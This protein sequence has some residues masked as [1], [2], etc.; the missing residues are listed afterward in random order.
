MAADLWSAAQDASTW[1]KE[2]SRLVALMDQR[3]QEMEALQEKL[4][5]AI[6]APQRASVCFPCRAAPCR[7]YVGRRCVPPHRSAKASRRC[8]ESMA[9]C[10]STDSIDPCSD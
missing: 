2:R 6:A 8:S 3:R 5:E 7:T 1:E 4:L 9:P 10:R